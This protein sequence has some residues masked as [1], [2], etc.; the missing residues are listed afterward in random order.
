MLSPPFRLERLEN[1]QSVRTINGH[2]VGAHASLGKTGDFMRQL[3]GRLARLTVGSK[4]L[5]GADA[6]AFVRSHLAAR[7]DDVERAPLTD[8]P[9][10]AHGSAI[11]ERNS[12]PTTIHAD[13]GALRH[14]A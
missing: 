8:Q 4:P 1:G 10:Q 3:L 9:R 5:A 13:I 12:P 11:D 14:D 2:A 7:E 6:V